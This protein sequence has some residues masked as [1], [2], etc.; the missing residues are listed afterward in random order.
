MEVCPVYLLVLTVSLWQSV[1][2]VYPSP[3]LI[4]GIAAW[5]F[6]ICC[7]CCGYGCGF[8]PRMI[9]L[10]CFLT[11]LFHLTGFVL[12][13][14]EI[15]CLQPMVFGSSWMC[16]DI[17]PVVLAFWF[18]SIPSLNYMSG[19]LDVFFYLVLVTF[20]AAVLTTRPCGLLFDFFVDCVSF[21]AV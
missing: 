1:G 4:G 5:Y 2:E 16:C 19:C 10:P 17:I 3:G 21:M 7:L 8:I 11:C 15:F 14:T 9:Y 13:L 20:G 6:S 12:F 18:F